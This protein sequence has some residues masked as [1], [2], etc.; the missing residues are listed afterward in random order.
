[1]RERILRTRTRI[2]NRSR[3]P[4]GTDRTP[5]EITETPADHE[6]ELGHREIKLE[7]GQKLE[8]ERT[9]NVGTT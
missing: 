2:T 4:M 1:M 3:T 9:P 8:Q 7:H 6:T 5:R